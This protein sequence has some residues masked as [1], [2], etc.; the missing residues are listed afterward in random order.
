MIEKIALLPIFLILTINLFANQISN[1]IDYMSQ[2]EDLTIKQ[3]LSIKDLFRLIS[4]ETNYRFFYSNKLKDINKKVKIN[5][6][7]ANVEN[8]L[9][10]AFKGLAL[11]CKINGDEILV[12]N[13]KVKKT[14]QKKATKRPPVVTGNVT[15]EIDNPL[16]GV[17]IVVRGTQKGT[18]T[19]FDGNFSIE[20]EATD[21]LVFSYMGFE[22][23]TILVGKQSFLQIKMLP[24]SNMLE[25][26]IIAGVAAGT[27]KKKMSVSVT[28][29]KSDAINSVPQSSVS[30]A[31][32]GKMAGVS[33]TSL[34]GSPGSGASLNLRGAT[35]I[36]GNQTPLILVDGVQMQGS[37]ADINVDDVE[38][39]EVVKGA[40]A[41]SLYGSKAGN[42]VVVITSK[43]GKENTQGK[44][45]ISIKSRHEV[46]RLSKYL[47]LSQSHPYML[48]P[49]WLDATTYTKYYGVE[50]P[51][52]YASGWNPDIVGNRSEKY[53]HYMDMPY[54]INNDH[55]KAMFTDGL[56]HTNH[57]GLGYKTDKTNTYFSF[58]NNADQGVIIETGGYKRKSLRGNFDYRITDKLYFSTS[59]N[60]IMTN[61]NFMGGSNTFFEVLMME[62]D[63]DLFKDNADGQ[64]YDYFPNNW[65]TQFGNPLYK[66]WKIEENSEKNRFMGNYK[67]KWTLF[68][69]MNVEA[70]YSLESQKYEKNELTPEGTYVGMG[71]DNTP[72]QSQRIDYKYNSTILNQNYKITANFSRSWDKLDFKGK[73]SYLFEDSHFDWFDK[74]STETSDEPHITEDDYLEEERAVNYFAIASFVYN[75]R[76]IF[77][78]LFRYDGSSL[79]GSNE[80]W[81][82]YFRLSGAYRL[83]KDLKI[84]GVNELKLRA[85]YGTAGQR[86]D[87]HMQYETLIRNTDGSISKGRLGNE[88]LKPSRS[89]EK[90]FGIDA[91]FLNRFNLETTYSNTIT[92]DQFIRK[93]LAAHIEGH[94]YQY[95]NVGTLETTTFEAMLN[96]K[97][98]TNNNFKWNLGVTFDNTQSIITELEIPTYYDGPRGVFKMETGGEYGVFY[99]DSFVTTLDQLALQL[100]HI[101]SQYIE[102]SDASIDNFS[103]NS[104][105]FVV[106]T[107]HIGTTEEKPFKVLDENGEPKEML[108][109]NVN[110]DFRMGFNTNLSYKNFSVYTLWKWKKG[111]DIYNA[112][113]QYLMRDF[114]HPMMDQRFTPQDEKKTFDYYQHL[115]DA[116]NINSF[117]VEDASYVR[118]S[119]V[120]IYYDLSL[121]NSPLKNMKI[122]LIGKNIY[123]F[124]DYTGYDPESGYDGFVFDNYGYPNFSSYALAINFNF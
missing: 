91:H 118:L 69:W 13:K 49:D 121:K 4:E 42:G 1:D 104:D 40:A 7:N 61:N 92:K 86:P 37:L 79:F 103:I 78:G 93:Y 33:V 25:E 98:I 20:A 112:T 57:I 10:I 30:S 22:N 11:E 23:Q 113:A 71:N 123:T 100:D 80:R 3:E 89:T 58:E 54:R 67:V 44:L 95:D 32:S 19:D 27:S 81:H 111:G 73:L 35:N 124:T 110:P 102:Y 87:F 45:A 47:E 99:G 66:L 68:D 107:N 38:S 29:I 55:Q 84:K 90:E 106:Y 6:T 117:W 14:I 83:T 36:L 24:S 17:N 26:V 76:Y 46:Q 97:I 16:P 115:Y 77:D 120:S 65:N 62:P 70:S 94:T 52:N 15:D 8:I 51:E 85:S 43:R 9:Q 119:E 21:Y 82:P 18:T 116:T 56:S 31:L 60:Y 109:G 101:N 5:V 122:G 50:Y 105:G 59:N 88:N 28:K 41:S 39:I 64:K 2:S 72:R 48:A 63:V 114:R 96:A 12:R 108:I 74:E 53:D 75:D 34:S